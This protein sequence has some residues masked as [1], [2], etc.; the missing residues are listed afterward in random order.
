MKTDGWLD[1]D[2]E[3]LEEEFKEFEGAFFKKLDE[4]YYTKW[5]LL[6]KNISNRLHL[7]TKEKTSIENLIHILKNTYDEMD[8]I[9]NNSIKAEKNI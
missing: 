4:Q 2:V 5:N 3:K 9:E 7:L 1:V 8:S 6:K